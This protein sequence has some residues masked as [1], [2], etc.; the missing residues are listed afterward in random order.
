MQTF[1]DD[2]WPRAALTCATR[3]MAAVATMKSDEWRDLHLKQ[4][5]AFSADCVHDFSPFL[6]LV[7]S[8]PSLYIPLLSGPLTQFSNDN[9]WYFFPDLAALR[10]LL[11]KM[12]V[13]DENI[14]PDSYRFLLD[15]IKVSRYII[16]RG[17]FGHFLLSVKDK[18]VKMSR[19]WLIKVS[20]QTWFK[21]QERDDFCFWLI[22]SFS[23]PDLSLSL[24][25]S[26]Q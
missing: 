15:H 6:S 22:T 20:A 1:R 25:R 7:K 17:I 8:R 13:I 14:P 24:S 23:K 5:L 19:L 3:L 21:G 10:S 4:S 12:R 9:F 11:R 2:A 16:E 18:W 26:S